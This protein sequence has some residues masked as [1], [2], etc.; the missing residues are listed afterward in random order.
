MTC[1]DCLHCE[2]KDCAVKQEPEAPPPVFR[3]SGDHCHLCEIDCLVNQD[4]KKREPESY[5]TG[6]AVV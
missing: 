3:C 2:V 1:P 6:L 4:L 5:R